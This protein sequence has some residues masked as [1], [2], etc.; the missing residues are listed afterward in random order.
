MKIKL[1]YTAGDQLA[2]EIREK[3]TSAGHQIVTKGEEKTVIVFSKNLAKY[4]YWLTELKK[5]SA[6]SAT[7]AGATTILGI[8]EEGTLNETNSNLYAVITLPSSERRRD[9]AINSL[10]KYLR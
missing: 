2:E 1:V 6:L 9:A 8:A 5:G 7:G 4:D 3:L 10:L